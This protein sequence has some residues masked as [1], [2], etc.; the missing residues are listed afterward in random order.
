MVNK[1]VSLHIPGTRSVTYR[2]QQENAHLQ[3]GEGSGN[4]GHEGR[5]GELG[6]SGGGGG[7]GNSYSFEKGGKKITLSNASTRTSPVGERQAEIKLEVNGKEMMISGVSESSMESTG[8]A[9][10]VD[11]KSPTTSEL[12]SGKEYDRIP[13]TKETHDFVKSEL[14]NAIADHVSEESSKPIE[15][16]SVEKYSSGKL[17]DVNPV[18]IDTPW[19]DPALNIK[20]QVD[21]LS[22]SQRRAFTENLNPQITS[23]G[24]VKNSDLI[25]SL[26]SAKGTPVTEIHNPVAAARERQSYEIDKMESGKKYADSSRGFDKPLYKQEL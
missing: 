5:P 24:T 2:A 1:L 6:G 12:I 21:A 14:S 19:H 22:T 18:G 17:N 11:P 7:G 9:M 20:S 8:Y 16:W 23:K 26:S 25:S 15:N 4:F 13:I 3:G 10:Y